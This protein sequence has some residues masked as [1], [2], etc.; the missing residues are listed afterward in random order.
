MP[1]AT[2]ATTFSGLSV[3]VVPGG[4]ISL[5]P[6]ACSTDSNPLRAAGKLPR[7]VLRDAHE[8]HL[9]AAA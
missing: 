4:L 2:T 1:N 7:N 5:M 3:Q 9:L 8:G 6:Q